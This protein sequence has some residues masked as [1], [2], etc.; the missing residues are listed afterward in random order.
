MDPFLDLLNA[1]IK[2]KLPEINTTI[3]SVIKSNGLDPIVN[4]AS[5]AVTIGSIDLGLCTA[6]VIASYKLENLKGLSTFLINTLVITS[7]T[8]SPDGSELYGTIQMNASLTSD[9]GIHVGG[10]LKA[11]CG[12][13]KS[14]IDIGGSVDVSSVTINAAGDFNASIGSSICL[15]EIDIMNPGLS[16]GKITIYIDNLGIFN[17]LLQPLEDLILNLVKGYVISSV[18]GLLT[19]VVNDA[20][21]GLLPLCTNLD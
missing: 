20:I 13:L 11:Q 15:T 14:S 7:A 9:I 10:K 12:V 5:G 1:L 6:E 18:Q 4:V 17:K 21:N 8:S 16:Y 2:G 3:S 19:P